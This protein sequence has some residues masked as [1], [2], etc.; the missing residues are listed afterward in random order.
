MANGNVINR[1]GNRDCYM[2]PHGIYP[3]V[4]GRHVAIATTSE[5]QWTRLCEAMGHPEWTQDARFIS[6]ALRKQNEDELDSL[7]ADWTKGF[8]AEQVMAM[9]QDAGVPAGAVQRGQEVLND[10]QLKHRGHYQLL[11]HPEI[12]PHSYNSPAYRLSGTPGEP[13]RPAPCLGEHNLYVYK[14]LLGMSDDEIAEMVIDGTITTEV[15]GQ[16]AFAGGK[17]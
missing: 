14:E 9:L 17:G 5:E 8:S 3:C 2:C 6:V 7:I 15:D 13:K 11:N 10:P 12:G 16:E 4:E 1:M